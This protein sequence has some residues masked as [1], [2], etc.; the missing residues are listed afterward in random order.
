[1]ALRTD[2]TRQFDYPPGTGRT[3]IDALADPPASAVAAA[4]RSDNLV[5]K[6]SDGTVAHIGAGA[7]PPGAT[8]TARPKSLAA[9]TNPA[10]PAYAHRDAYK[11]QTD[12]ASVLGPGAPSGAT[13][14]TL[15]AT[16]APLSWTAPVGGSYPPTGYRVEKSVK[17]GAVWGA[18]GA[19]VNPAGTATTATQ[20]GT[21]GQ[22]LRFR[23]FTVSGPRESTASNVVTVTLP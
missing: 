16:T 15:T 7:A 3:V 17:S 20:T 22:N 13:A 5:D 19:G 1:M 23:V 21:T 12:T 4:T 6:G 2:Q 11:T 8:N 9:A 18:W 14:G 10:P